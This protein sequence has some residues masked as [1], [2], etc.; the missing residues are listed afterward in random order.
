[1]KNAPYRTHLEKLM[2]IATTE[3][4]YIMGI[5]KPV[6]SSH[7]SRYPAWPGLVFLFVILPLILAPEYAR[8]EAVRHL[9][10]RINAPVSIGDVDLNPFT[11]RARIHDLVIGGD[12]GS[13]AVLRVPTLDVTLDRDALLVRDVIIHRVTAH[14]LALH[15]ERTGATTWNIDRIIRSRWEGGAS[16]GAFR[17]EQ[18]QVK[19]GSITVVDRTTTPAVANVLRNLDLTLRP[20]PLL[21]ESEPGQIVGEARLGEGSVQMSGTLHLNPFTNHLQLTA[22]SVPIAGFHGYANEIVG[23]TESVKGTFDGKLDVTAALD[24]RGYLAIDV[25]GALTGR[26][27]TLRM[28]GDEKPFFYATRLKADLARLSLMPE[29]HVEVPTVQVTEAT[30]RVTRDPK[31]TFNVRR[32]WPEVLGKR[33]VGTKRAGPSTTAPPLV[34]QHLTLEKSRVEFVDATLTPAFTGTMSNM[35]AEVHNRYPK[36]DRADLKLKGTL[37][38]AAPVTLTGWFTPVARPPKVYIQGTVQDFELSRVNP[39][40]EKYVRHPVRRGRVTTGVE[41]AYNAGN[42]DAGN[43]I[44]IRQIKVGDPLDKEFEAEV[45]IPLKL[46]VG[47]LEGLDGEIHIQVPVR[48]DLDNPE[49]QLDS[50]VWDAVRNAILK[51]ITVPFQVFG[52]ILQAGGK[53]LSVQIEP[54]SFRPGSVTPDARGEKRLEELVT[55]LRKRPKLELEI[56]GQAS[57]TEGKALPADRR[58]GRVATERELRKL[59]EDRARYIEQTLARRGIARKRLFVL[60]GEPEAVSEDGPGR[61][62][63]RML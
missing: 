5:E 58:H 49:M 27:V 7:P 48:G 31:G 2:G 57:L 34:V 25:Q 10:T 55:F 45:G 29:L 53:I 4:V 20:V 60:K 62:A 12:G 37:A 6:R 1:M 15:L 38:G 11:G 21:P 47:L 33:A 8:R 28:A 14:R 52:K 16:L 24:S 23:P 40:A 26:G 36:K 56:E 43:E 18:I 39:Y 54:V 50:V 46:A 61:V 42:I 22:T 63:F 59:A 51:A 13:D 35:S 9:Q 19:D 30:V 3:K 41:Y 44:R 32:L 17:I